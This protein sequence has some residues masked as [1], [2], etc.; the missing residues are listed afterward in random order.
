M[1]VPVGMETWSIATAGL[2]SVFREGSVGVEG[3]LSVP[4]FQ[5]RG[6]YIPAGE[7]QNRQTHM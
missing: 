2:F 1:P 6:L 5:V 7:L 3:S 4:P